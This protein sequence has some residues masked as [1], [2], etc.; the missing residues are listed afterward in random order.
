MSAVDNEKYGQVLTKGVGATLFVHI[1]RVATNINTVI[2]SLERFEKKTEENFEKVNSRLDNIE[3]GITELKGDVK[4]INTRLDNVEG[5]IVK[6]NTR[7]DNIEDDVAEL[8]D[9]VAE[10]KGDV[11]NINKNLNMLITHLMKTPINR[12]D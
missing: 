1:N 7:L 5:E 12:K 3:N 2:F 4:T 8:K 9:D 10:L 11:K 6:V